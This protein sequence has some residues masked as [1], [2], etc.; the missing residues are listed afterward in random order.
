M[1]L[2]AFLILWLMYNYAAHAKES[3]PILITYWVNHHSDDTFWRQK[4]KLG[5]HVR[6]V[7]VVAAATKN[8][9]WTYYHQRLARYGHKCGHGQQMDLTSIAPFL[10]NSRVHVHLSH[11]LFSDELGS[12]ICC[13]SRCGAHQ[14]VGFEPLS[15]TVGQIIE[16]QSQDGNTDFYPLYLQEIGL[17]DR[18]V[19]DVDA[20]TTKNFIRSYYHQRL[21]R[22]GHKCGQ[23]INLTK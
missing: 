9:L 10:D 17:V 5:L 14:H 7:E 23:Q 18:Y 15:S 4:Q 2:T 1:M 11:S 16:L 21:A 13:T 19:V 20:A 22:Y 12:N 8:W 6:V 3:N